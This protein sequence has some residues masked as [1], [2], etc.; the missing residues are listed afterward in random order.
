MA[1][2]EFHRKLAKE[3]GYP[4]YVK[5][6]L[7]TFSSWLFQGVLYMDTTEKYFKIL[8]DIFIILPIFVILNFYLNIHSSLFLAIILAHTINWVFNGQIFVLLKNLELSRTKEKSF[9]EYLNTIREKVENENSIIAVAAFGSLSNKK[10]K[11]T[12]DLDIRL[13]RRRGIINGIKSCIFVL[14]ERTSSFFSGFPLDIY[15]LDNCD[16]I[17]RHIKNEKP[18]ILYDPENILLY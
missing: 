12:S 8:L 9:V 17:N 6:P 3:N 15:L 11:K 16:M 14:K 5:I 10:L 13:I 18:F 4:T 7:L 1:L 2:N